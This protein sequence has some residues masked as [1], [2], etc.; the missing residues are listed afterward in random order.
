MQKIEELKKEAVV[1]KYLIDNNIE[2]M[3]EIEDVSVN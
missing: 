1:L 2:I 3:D